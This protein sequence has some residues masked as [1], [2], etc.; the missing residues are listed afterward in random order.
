[1]E[2]A[3]KAP[4]PK[5]QARDKCQAP[6]NISR[7]WELEL[8]FWSFFGTWNLGF[9]ALFERLVLQIAVFRTEC[10]SA[11]KRGCRPIVPVSRSFI[12]PKTK[13]PMLFL[14]K[15]NS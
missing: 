14:T 11:A 7:E 10:F 2:A 13:R 5:H 9:G 8:G 12:L 15:T 4:N 3:S 1:M 6:K